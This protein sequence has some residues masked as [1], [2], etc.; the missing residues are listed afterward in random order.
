MKVCNVTDKVDSKREN[1]A[2]C[3][4]Q[5]SCTAKRMVISKS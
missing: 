4:I 3:V 5:I 1:T 2:F